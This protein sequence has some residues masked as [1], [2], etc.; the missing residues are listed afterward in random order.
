VTNKI[1]LLLILF[2]NSCALGPDYKRV[3]VQVPKQYKEV[4]GLDWQVIQPQEAQSANSW[5]EIFND[6]ILNQLQI[7]LNKDNYNIK[8]AEHSYQKALALVT[9]ARTEYLPVVTSSMNLSRQKTAPTSTTASVTSSKH[10]LAL[11]AS[12]ELDFWGNVNRS[13]ESK[14]ASALSAKALLAGAKLSVQASLAQYYFELRMLD[15]NQ[16]LLD[17]IMTCNGVLSSYTRNRFSEGIGDGQDI[18]L[19]EQQFE[20]AKA[21]ALNNKINRAQYEH[22]IATLIGDLPSNFAIAP[23]TKIA[24]QTISVPINIPSL[25]LE[26]RPDVANAETNVM[27]ASA[28]IGIAKSAFFPVLNL[29][30][31]IT[32]QGN[33]L[34]NLLSAPTQIWSVGPQLAL[35][36]T[37]MA[38]YSAT[39]KAAEADYNASVATYRQTALNAFKDVEDCLVSFRILQEQ[40]AIQKIATGKAKQNLN[41]VENH[42]KSGIVDISQVLLAQISYYNSELI[43]NNLQ[44]YK[45][46]S[47]INLVTALGGGW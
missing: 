8:A 37:D 39:M 35:N 28:N 32:Y 21:Q 23:N 16:E 46:T 14:Q 4:N 22:A 24:Y 44:G 1:I 26:R 30:A 47:A 12:W 40:E 7:K 42:Y 9:K 18:A 19:I 36:I 43:L 13:V 29:G 10:N 6:P 11:G 2:L 17:N 3:E 20:N 31:N 41:I 34:G 15:K 25:L 45:A 5:W 38:A 27:I 33:G